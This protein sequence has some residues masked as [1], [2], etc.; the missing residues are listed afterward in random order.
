LL[1]LGIV[2]KVFIFGAIAGVACLSVLVEMTKSLSFHGDSC[3]FDDLMKSRKKKKMGCMREEKIDK[4]QSRLSH[5][6]T[7]CKFCKEQLYQG[8]EMVR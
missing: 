8:R 2:V 7:Y 1:Q 3:L 5:H 6:Y 4:N